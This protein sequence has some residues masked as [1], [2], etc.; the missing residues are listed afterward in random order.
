MVKL[1]FS[2]CSTHSNSYIAFLVHDNCCYDRSSN[3]HRFCVRIKDSRVK[4]GLLLSLMAMVYSQLLVYHLAS[5]FS[6][7]V[8]Y[9]V[10][11]FNLMVYHLISQYINHYRLGLHH[12][13]S[14][15]CTI[16]PVV[17]VKTI[18]TM[19]SPCHMANAIMVVLNLDWFLGQG[20]ASA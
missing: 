15:Q 8:F 13:S 3:F 9:L 14:R 4:R 6:L 2:V 17:I 11:W 12:C 18:L 5:W 7:M 20:K 19:T 10:P 16:F 1:D